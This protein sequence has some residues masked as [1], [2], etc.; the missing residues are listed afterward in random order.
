[1]LTILIKQTVRNL[2]CQYYQPDLNWCRCLERAASLPLDDGSI[3]RFRGA[4]TITTATLLLPALIIE[5]DDDSIMCVNPLAPLLDVFLH[6]GF[7]P[8]YYGKDFKINRLA[9]YNSAL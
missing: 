1:M 2:Y 4:R 6:A 7:P 5:G 8:S 9:I 3:A